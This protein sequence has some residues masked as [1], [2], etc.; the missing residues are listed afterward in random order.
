MQKAAVISTLA[1]DYVRVY[2]IAELKSTEDIPMIKVYFQQDFMNNATEFIRRLDQHF[3]CQIAD[4]VGYIGEHEESPAVQGSQHIICYIR[5]LKNMFQGPEV[6]SGKALLN[7]L[8]MDDAEI[9]S[10]WS[11]QVAVGI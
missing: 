11:I 3:E 5:V 6:P 8:G 9:S 10:R 4:A 1:G 2:L 7:I